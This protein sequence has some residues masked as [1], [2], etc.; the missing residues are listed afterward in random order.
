MLYGAWLSAS[1]L[2]GGMMHLDSP[3][4]RPCPEGWAPW[5]SYT[6]PGPLEVSG[7]DVQ[8]DALHSIEQRFTANTVECET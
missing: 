7:V 8:H 6:Y 2:G 5:N 3:S 1:T 4:G